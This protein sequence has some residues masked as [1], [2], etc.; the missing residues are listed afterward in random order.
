MY[1]YA[2]YLYGV[3]IVATVDFDA[4]DSS[5]VTGGSKW[6]AKNCRY[7]K[8]D[9]S[10]TFFVAAEGPELPNSKTIFAER[11]RKRLRRAPGGV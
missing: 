8:L 5:L 6:L 4:P 3:P 10:E 1:S 2:V 7:L 11:L 9:E